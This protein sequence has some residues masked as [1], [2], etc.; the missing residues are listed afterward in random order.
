[1]YVLLW[2]WYSKSE[3]RKAAVDTQSKQ[4][5]EWHEN[6]NTVIMLLPIY[7]ASADLAIEA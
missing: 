2:P 6:H 1:M 7:L 4:T 3:G 5:Q